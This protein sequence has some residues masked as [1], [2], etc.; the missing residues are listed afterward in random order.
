[1]CVKMQG[2]ERGANIDSRKGG[3]NRSRRAKEEVVQTCGPKEQG[4]D[5]D[6][7]GV[8]WFEGRVA[9]AHTSEARNME[10]LHV[11]M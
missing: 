7:A 2:K 5:N 8:R 4:N 6:D 9:I 11:V 3:R 1:M 10:N